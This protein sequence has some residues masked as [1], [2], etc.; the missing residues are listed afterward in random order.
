MARVIS[1]G[2]F[3][4]IR[5]IVIWTPEEKDKRLGVMNN[6]AYIYPLIPQLPTIWQIEIRYDM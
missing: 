1:P 2:G 4:F 3:G 5:W 6:D